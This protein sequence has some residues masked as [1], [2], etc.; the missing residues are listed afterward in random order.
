MKEFIFRNLPEVRSTHEV[1]GVPSVSARFGT[2]PFFWNW[3]M[4]AMTYLFSPET[5]RDRSKVK[6]LVQLFD[7][8]V[9]AFDGI[10]G[11]RV[12]MRVDL[13][14]SDGS[15]KIGVF[16]HRKLSASVGIST[17]AFVLAV[18][19]GSAQPGVWFPEEPEGIKVEAREVLLQRAS[20]GTFNFA[21]VDGRNSAERARIRDLRV[22]LCSDRSNQDYA[23][24]VR[25]DFRKMSQN[26]EKM[27]YIAGIFAEN[28][29]D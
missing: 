28:R 17:S 8:F 26:G 9:R 2:S 3:G 1:L 14:Q 4:E 21:S 29:K 18:L 10:A 25:T 20:Q 16:S 24:T 27:L 15:N 6:Q 19:E 12:S 5:L 11:E 23:G 7:P 13:D 22:R